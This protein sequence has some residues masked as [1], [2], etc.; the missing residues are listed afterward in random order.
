[1]NNQQGLDAATTAASEEQ[2]LSLGDILR[3][4]WRQAWLILLLALVFMGMAVG[5]SILQTPTYESSIKILVGQAQA[6]EASDTNLSASDIQGLQILTRTMVE[7]IET[8]RVA[9]AVIQESNLA[10]APGKLMDDV[11][12]E[13]VPE[14]QFIRVTYEDTNPVRAQQVANTYGEVI[15]REVSDVSAAA[16]AV[17]A[18]VWEQATVENDPVSPQPLRNAVL[19]LLLGATLGVMLAFLLESLND[20]WRSAA[21]VERASGVPTVGVIP[22]FAPA[23]KKR[24]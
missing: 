20:G 10:V 6:A 13:Q 14:T 4:L 18:T 24:G 9:E 2:T 5:Y 17:T 16:S 21:E 19:G 8:R 7:A 15:P 12:A 11:N 22:T 1:M 23:G 3:M